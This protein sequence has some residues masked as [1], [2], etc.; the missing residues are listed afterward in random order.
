[1]CCSRNKL[2]RACTTLQ[3]PFLPWRVPGKSLWIL[4]LAPKNYQTEPSCTFSHHQS[5]GWPS[6]PRHLAGSARINARRNRTIYGFLSPYG[7]RLVPAFSGAPIGRP[8]RQARPWTQIPL[9]ADTIRRV[10]EQ[11]TQPRIGEPRWSCR[12]V[13]RA[14]GISATTVHKLWAANDLKPHLTRTFK[15]SNDP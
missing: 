11:V 13:A 1:V 3:V 6:S 7:H 10:L 8:A 14:A 15:L 2:L 9:P 4:R 5:A 12:S